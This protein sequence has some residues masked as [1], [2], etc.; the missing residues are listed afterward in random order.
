[1]MS[2]L[3]FELSANEQELLSGGQQNIA[4]DPTLTPLAGLRGRPVNPVGAGTEINGS[5]TKLK[6]NNLRGATNSG[7]IGSFGN[8]TGNGRASSTGAE[9]TMILPPFLGLSQSGSIP[10]SVR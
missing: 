4:G 7:P 10:F 9:D 1:M 5:E 6:N 2:I 8:S 3:L